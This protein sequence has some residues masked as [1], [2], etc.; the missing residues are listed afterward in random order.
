METS[1]PQQHEQEQ[2]RAHGISETNYFAVTRK[3]WCFMVSV[4]VYWYHVRQA[5]SHGRTVGSRSRARLF[6]GRAS[7][8]S[9]KV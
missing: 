1:N 9:M 4:Y 8:K 5:C 6:D 7:K 2:D 3:L